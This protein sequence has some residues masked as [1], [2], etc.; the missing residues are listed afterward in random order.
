MHG[1]I[2]RHFILEEKKSIILLEG[3]Q[4]SPARPS[5]KESVKLEMLGW[6][7]LVAQVGAAEV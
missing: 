3:S 5:D 4:A 1:R 6:L 7:G 2:V